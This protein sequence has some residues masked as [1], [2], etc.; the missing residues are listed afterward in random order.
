[1]ARMRRLYSH[2][3]HPLVVMHRSSLRSPAVQ[4]RPSAA[5]F[6]P[7][8]TLFFVLRR[9]IR[10]AMACAYVTVQ[11]AG[12]V[13]GVY[14][15]HAMFAAPIFEISTQLRDG[16][17]QGLAECIATFGLLATIAGSI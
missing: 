1:M 13:I 11:I 9:A 4:Q 15:A 7:A 12:A 16:A 6:N 8:V 14:L 17:T 5:H 2:K 3:R 10:P